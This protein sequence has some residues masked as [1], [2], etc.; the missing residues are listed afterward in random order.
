MMKS[1][2]VVMAAALTALMAAGAFGQTTGNEWFQKAGEYLD[3]GDY[4]N[5]VTAYGETIKR[6][7]SNL[8]A[9]LLRS[10][11]YYQLKNY[12]AAIADCDTIIKGAPD[13]PNV[14]VVRGD[15]YGAKGIY[16]KAAA[17]YRTGLAKGYDPGGFR[18]DTSS[19]ADMWFCG[20][21]YMEIAVN[22]FLGTSDAV[23]TYENGLK[24]VCDK[25]NVTRAEV[26]TFYRQGVEN[27]VRETVYEEFNKISFSLE[28]G[29]AIS[30]NAVLMRNPKTE[31]YTLIYE[32]PSVANDDKELA[33]PT[34]DALLTEMKKNTAAF[35]QASI[36]EVHAQAAIIP[37]VAYGSRRTGELALITEAI[38][39]F[40]INPNNTTWSAITGIYA[41]IYRN[42]SL[43]IKTLSN[44]AYNSFYKALLVLQ[45]GLAEKLY[46]DVRPN[47]AERLAR[48][49][50][51]PRYDIFSNHPGISG[52]R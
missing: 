42:G 25:N 51:D 7:S 35:N 44:K 2:M 9:Y 16:H 28:A 45:K 22:R 48:I 50:N 3:G 30:Y 20:A 17:D 19:K 37:A 5:A 38:K 49:P 4:A 24:A 8:D 21:L 41:R 1:K 12:G 47:T 14:Y 29:Y 11:A 18:V 40:Y 15:A 52:G 27:L 33:A 23:T 36:N 13:F 31:Q 26:E 39:D 34:L 10:F 6:N 46:Q 43:D 32:R